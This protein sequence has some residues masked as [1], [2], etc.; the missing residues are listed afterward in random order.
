LPQIT[1]FFLIEVGTDFFVVAFPA[2]L[3]YACRTVRVFLVMPVL[4]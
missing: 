4:G 1:D 3:L 2:Q